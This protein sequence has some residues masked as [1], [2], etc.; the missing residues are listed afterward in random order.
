MPEPY[1]WLP[2]AER[3]VK[4]KAIGAVVKS[5]NPTPGKDGGSNSSSSSVRRD[6]AAGFGGEASEAEE[7]A[8]ER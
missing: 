5:T 1:D 7:H 2:A 3:E 8:E 6:G 4:L